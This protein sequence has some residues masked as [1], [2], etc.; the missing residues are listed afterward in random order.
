L[1]LIFIFIVMF[2]PGGLSGAYYRLRMK[3]LARKHS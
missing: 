3:A 2:A 1:G